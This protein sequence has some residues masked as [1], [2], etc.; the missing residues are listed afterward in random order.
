MHRAAVP[1]SSTATYVLIHGVGDVEWYWHLIEGELRR[2][3]HD[4]VVVD[5]P[6]DD[7]SAGLSAYAD[8]VVEAIGD[9]DNLVV[10]AQSFAGHVAP[11]V[12]DRIRATLLV[13]VAGMVPS[14]ASLRKRCSRTSGTR[15]RNTGILPAIRRRSTT[16]S[17]R[18]WRSRRSP[19]DGGSRKRRV[20][21][22]G[23]WLRGPTFRRDI[24]CAVIRT[25]SSRGMGPP[26]C[27]RS[28]RHR[29]RRDGQR[30]YAGAESSQGAGRA[31]RD[32]PVTFLRRGPSS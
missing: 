16:T 23:R 7:D 30:S 17:S 26:C 20:R 32:V 4:V 9:R 25:G 15:E 8:V 1:G 10:V 27:A 28:P 21:S 24:C 29:S 14:R 2:R 6:V 11:I 3:G 5:L 19:R 31:A 22:L 18:R 12:C 13:L